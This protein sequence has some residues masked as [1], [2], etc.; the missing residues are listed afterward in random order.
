MA[1]TACHPRKGRPLYKGT[2]DV[3]KVLINAEF[4]KGCGLCVSTCPRGILKISSSF[5][6]HGYYPVYVA[7]AEE[8]TGCGLCAIV[9]PDVALSVYREEKTCKK[10]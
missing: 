2:M 10:S 1:D 3:N 9:C 6:T 8:C 4:C 7:R 5:N